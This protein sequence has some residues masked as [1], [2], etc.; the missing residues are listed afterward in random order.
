MKT[1]VIN[2]STNTTGDIHILPEVVLT[3]ATEVFIDLYEV[4]TRNNPPLFLNIEW[5]DGSESI[6]TGSNFTATPLNSDL[7]SAATQAQNIQLYDI[8]IK[9]YSHVYTPSTTCLTKKL[10]CFISIEHLTLNNQTKFII[11][12]KI[13]TPSY[14]TKIGD[15]A[16]LQTNIISNNI[17]LLTLGTE[18]DSSIIETSFDISALN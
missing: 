11:P 13:I 3:D 10:S 9:Q 15:M 6:T 12:I 17:A 5:G 16:I 1:F 14:Y 7:V 8:L 2:L 18:N 4:E